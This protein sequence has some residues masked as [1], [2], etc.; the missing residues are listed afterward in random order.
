MQ[1][2]LWGILF[3]ATFLPIVLLMVGSGVAVGAKAGKETRSGYA[4]LRWL[5]EHT[6]E[7]RDSHG[8]T[9]PPGDRRLTSSAQY[10]RAFILIGSACA[11]LSPAI[12]ILRLVIR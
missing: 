5:K 1:G 7:V 8:K 6:T 11:V 10:M 2:K 9:I 4:T 3:L 12:W